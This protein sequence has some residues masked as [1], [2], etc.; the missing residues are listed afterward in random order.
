M[1]SGSADVEGREPGGSDS[2]PSTPR[3]RLPASLGLWF[4]LCHTRTVRAGPACWT[5]VLGA[6]MGE[7]KWGHL[8]GAVDG[9][10]GRGGGQGSHPLTY[11]RHVAKTFQDP[12]SSALSLPR[13]QKSSR[14]FR[15]WCLRVKN[16]QLSLPPPP[17]HSFFIVYVFG[18]LKVCLYSPLKYK[19]RSLRD[20]LIY[21][22]LS[23]TFVS[24]S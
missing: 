3:P 14:Q 16:T 1:T 6:E 19:N 18:N 24:R 23:P 2:L 22:G 15:S 7:S 11:C 12:M 9:E 5:D 20:T 4:V 13:L 21:K 10:A 8:P 17:L